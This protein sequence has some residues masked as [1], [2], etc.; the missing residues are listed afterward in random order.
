MSAFGQVK[1][2]D[3][4]GEWTACNKDSLYYKSEKVVLYQDANYYVE[5]KCCHYVNWKISTKKK[6]EIENSFT[7]SEPGRVNS[8]NAK[9]TFKILNCDDGQMIVLKRDGQEIDKFKIL[10]L[11]SKKV[12]RY[13]HNIKVLTLRRE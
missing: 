1:S 12:D 6:V 3:L 9:E 13:P 4:I 5:A 8:L 11:E 2:T 10:Q 7:C